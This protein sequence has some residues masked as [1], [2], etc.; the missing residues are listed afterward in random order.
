M[1]DD[2]SNWM[3]HSRVVAMP[4]TQEQKLAAI[5]RL[6]MSRLTEGE[7]LTPATQAR[8]D[9]YERVAL[10]ALE[11]RRASEKF[12]VLWVD[13][14]VL[15]RICRLKGKISRLVPIEAEEPSRKRRPRAEQR[16]SAACAVAASTAPEDLAEA[17]LNADA[18][19]GDNEV[20]VMRGLNCDTKFRA[21]GEV[22]LVSPG[23]HRDH[24][25]L[26]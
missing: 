9:E 24:K 10:P 20:A 25:V 1:A 7:R 21:V 4:W 22:P 26:I 16:R 17:P 18:H 12:N 13:R 2:V 6:D 14:H 11:A 23:A 15:A 3:P 19:R 8:C 5:R